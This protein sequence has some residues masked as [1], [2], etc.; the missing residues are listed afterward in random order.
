MGYPAKL[1]NPG[2]QVV[3]DVRPH[4]KYLDRP[5][6][7][8]TVVLAGACYAIVASVA[9]WVAV[10]LA[11]AL[12]VCLV[13]LVARYLR[14]A[15]TSLVV[16]SQRLVLRKGV[17]A[18]SGREILLDRLS[19]ISYHQSLLDRVLGAGDIMLESP[20]RDG[21][22][23]FEDLPH[24]VTIQ[25]EINR[26]VSLHHGSF[27]GGPGRAEGAGTGTGAVAVP[28]GAGG[29]VP[30]EGGAEAQAGPGPGVAEQLEQLDQLRRR[31]VISRRE[32]AAKKAELLSRL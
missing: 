31:G 2:E 26:L 25:S 30:A 8:V 28:G 29:P 7:A 5:L 11:C 6:F 12:A 3:L 32:F 19:D 24:P 9:R 4:W 23:I 13:W 16:T 27:W 15:A 10:A 17:F 20:G 14:W 21:Q 18:R 1:L 22:E